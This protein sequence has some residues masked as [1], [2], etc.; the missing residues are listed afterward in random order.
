MW[1]VMMAICT[2]VGADGAE[3]WHFD[4][5]DLSTPHRPLPGDWFCL[6]VM[7]DNF[8]PYVKQWYVQ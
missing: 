3:L 5:G 1:A 6:A 7:M 2:M 8:T 4:P